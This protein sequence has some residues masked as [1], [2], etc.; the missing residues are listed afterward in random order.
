MV[1]EWLT[2]KQAAEYLQIDRMTILRWIKAEKLPASKIGKSYRIAQ[3]ELEKY[4]NDRK[5]K[6]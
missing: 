4:L 6:P 5:G 2:V 3:K 1:N